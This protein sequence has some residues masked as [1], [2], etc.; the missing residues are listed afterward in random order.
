VSLYLRFTQRNGRTI[1]AERRVL[2]PYAITAPINRAG[3]AELTL[4]SI[5]GGLYGGEHVAQHIH[6]RPGAAARLVQPA[7]TTVRRRAATG[8]AR[9]TISLKAEENTTLVY[10][11]RPLIMLPDAA[12]EQN[13]E[14]TTSP[15]ARIMFWDGFASHNPKGEK[16]E[17]SLTSRVS[18]RGPDGKL[19]AT[20]RMAVD[21]TTLANELQGMAGRFSAFG[22]IWCLGFT[23]GQTMP[24]ISSQASFGQTLLPNNVG[25]AIALAAADGGALCAALQ[26]ILG[27]A[28]HPNTSWVLKPPG[29]A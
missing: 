24:D 12:L 11:T 15:G 2:Y 17:W 10:A 21:G 28:E 25:F 29:A 13:W 20:E 23:P 16:P 18:V 22:K 8:P 3:V 14:I 7:A 27:K 1:L 6:L 26:E 5:S 9:Q 4:Q 19:L